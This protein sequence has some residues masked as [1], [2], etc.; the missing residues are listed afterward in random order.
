MTNLQRDAMAYAGANAFIRELKKYRDT[1]TP[2]QIRTLKG[3]ALAGFVPEARRG[4][5]RLTEGKA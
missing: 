1:L 5:K 2:Q 4:L 3:Q